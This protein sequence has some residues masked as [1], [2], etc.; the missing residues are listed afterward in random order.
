MRLICSRPC[1]RSVIEAVEL[2]GWVSQIRPTLHPSWRSLFFGEAGNIGGAAANIHATSR[3]VPPFGTELTAE[4]RLFEE[5]KLCL[6][7]NYCARE[8]IG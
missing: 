4:V 8:M 5:G 7:A 3:R 1:G 2:V 6:K